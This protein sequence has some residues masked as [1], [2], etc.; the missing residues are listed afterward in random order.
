MNNPSYDLK[1][2]D[3]HLT[4]HLPRSKTDQW[5]QGDEVLIA[6]T[7]SETCPV[8]ILEEYMRRGRITISSKAKLFYPIVSGKS[9]KLRDYGGLP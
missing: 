3:S 1:F 7:G 5:Q 9:E 4:L 8:A 2:G 6:R